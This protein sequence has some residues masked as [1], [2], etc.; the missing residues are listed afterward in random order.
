[1]CGHRLKKWKRH[2]AA[3]A[4]RQLPPQPAPQVNP[5]KGK[6]RM[7][8]ARPIII[9]KKKGG[10][11]GH[12]GGAWKVAYADFVTAM[13]SLFIVLWLLNSSKQVQEAVGGYFKD[14][15]GTSK[16]VGT[17]MQGSGENFI[18]SKDNMPRLKDQLEQRIRQI[19]DFEKLKNHIEITVTAEGLRIELMES[20]SGTFFDSG[21]LKLNDDGRDLLIALAQELGNLPNK[22]SIEG[23]TDS[24]P[25]SGS[26][27]YSNW[28]L[29]TDRANAARR[30][31]QANGVRADQVTQVRGFADQRLRKPESPFD[32]ANRRISLIVQYLDKNADDETRP[33]AQAN[34]IGEVKPSAEAKPSA[35]K[36][37]IKSTTDGAKPHK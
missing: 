16:K 13:M 2:V 29:S 33:S 22:I 14:P 34:P 19:N 37:E 10:H 7:D 15:T 35:G 32:P 21:S 25:Y 6:L 26:G 36:E 20:A 23:H 9:V 31:M 28:E 18:L 4:L 5:G 1:M 27:N 24:K 30:L 12:H 17:D 3:A 8:N 11:G